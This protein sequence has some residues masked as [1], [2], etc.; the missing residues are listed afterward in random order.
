M[1]WNHPLEID[2]L[3]VKFAPL[4]VAPSI[5]IRVINTAVNNEVK[6]PIINVKANPLIGPVPN[7]YKMI[8]VKKVVMFASIIADKAPLK[9][10]PSSTDCF[11]PFFLNKP[12]LILSKI[13]CLMMLPSYFRRI[14]MIINP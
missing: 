10:K 5:K 11:N 12:S 3:N 7:T 14:P 8:P 1:F 2:V 6:I 13:I 9:L 4:F